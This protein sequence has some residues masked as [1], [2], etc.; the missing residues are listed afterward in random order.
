MRSRRG[1][2]SDQ[3]LAANARGRITLAYDEAGRITT[4]GYDLD[5]KALAT[6]RQILKP[7]NLVSLIP[8]TGQWANTAYAVDWPLSAGQT[9]RALADNL[10]DPTLYRT[11][12]TFDALGRRSALTAPL[13]ATGQRAQIA[14]H[15]G[16]GGGINA[17]DVD[18]GH[19]LQS[20][21]YDPHGRRSAAF[22][23]NGV[24]L[25]YLYD[26]QTFRLRRLF[27]RHATLA[28]T[29][30]TCD[31]DVLQDVGY[32][33]DLNGNVL[34]LGDR[35]PGCG[36][37]LGVDPTAVAGSKL[38]QPSVHLRPARPIADGPRPRDRLAPSPPY[39][40]NPRSVDLTKARPYTETYTYD[41]VDNLTALE[42]DTPLAA[43]AY[44]RAFTTAA[45]SNRLQNLTIGSYVWPYTYD[46]CGNLL[47]EATNRFFEWDHADRLATFRDQAGLQTATK[48][49]QYRY[50]TT[51]QRVVKVTC[52]G[53]A[54]IDEVTVYLGGFERTLVASADG[55]F[56]PY[57]EL[58]L[59]DH[60][61]R[62]VTILRGAVHPDDPMPDQPIRYQLGDHLTSVV[63]TLNA[64]GGVLSREEY[65]PYGET[66]FG[67]YARKR[68]RYTSKERDNE[69]S[70]AFHG[71]RYYAPW[72]GRWA[73][74]DP[75]DGTHSTSSY[76]YA[77]NQPTCRIDHDGRQDTP[78]PARTP[79]RATTPAPDQA[80]DAHSR[81][82]DA[83]AQNDPSAWTDEDMQE[84]RRRWT[85]LQTGTPIITA[86]NGYNKK[87]GRGI[88]Y[89]TSICTE[90]GVCD[91][92]SMR[93]AAS[94][95][96][97]EQTVA[98]WE[99]VVTLLTVGL[100]AVAGFKVATSTSTAPAAS[101][102]EDEVEQHPLRPET[103]RS[104]SPPAPNAG[105]PSRPSP[106]ISTS[107]RLLEIRDQ[108]LR[109]VRAVPGSDAMSP[110]RFGNTIDAAFKR[111]ARAAQAAGDLSPTLHI[112][113]RLPN[114]RM[115][116]GPDIYDVVTGEGWDLTTATDRQV[117]GH[118]NRYIGRAF[119]TPASVTVIRDINPL[120]L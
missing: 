48:Y 67:S 57:D 101:P 55:G 42:H 79:P 72:L 41:D 107:Q 27:A 3:A 85:T 2:T 77:A 20:V 98:R 11:D 102:E 91:W 76:I 60:G 71:A 7:E 33:Y 40:D 62:M 111:L 16:R 28:G 114:G 109:N 69:S 113:G 29:T 74:S 82:S 30:W 15:Y 116:P 39:E 96:H 115:E 4:A 103:G 25:R 47:T 92:D 75:A 43:G 9:D 10:L 38:P 100:A 36:L 52:K 119:G 95:Q 89:L 66:A 87:I 22:L 65:L 88:D 17:A 8:S 104:V 63:A 45:G 32:R 68:Y 99:N 1:L 6:T 5:G 24:L 106:T 37:P 53:S 12:A 70:L 64:S 84:L 108:A 112:T 90:T 117:A 120:V 118:D 31:G 46:A 49:A 21:I 23:G 83:V 80:S 59:T 13:D 50:D 81:P 61:S 105:P 26:P 34:T 58:D 94:L 19:H 86:D 56:T 93:Y 14:F 51:G 78:A 35:T 54:K 73:S 97:V 18:G 44:T 110:K